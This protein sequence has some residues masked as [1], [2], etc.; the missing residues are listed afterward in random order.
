MELNRQLMIH[1]HCFFLMGISTKLRLCFWTLALVDHCT[2]GRLVILN[3]IVSNSL[4]KRLEI[5]PKD[6]CAKIELGFP[7]VLI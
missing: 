1:L 5:G 2:S 3:G 4:C 7:S 6:V